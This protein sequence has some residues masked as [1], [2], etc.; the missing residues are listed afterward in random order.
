MRYIV[1]KLTLDEKKVLIEESFDYI[2]KMEIMSNISKLEDKIKKNVYKESF[3]V[4]YYLI[5]NG[6]N[7]LFHLLKQMS[8]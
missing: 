8:K 3:Y 5:K 1:P 7:D 6:M 2:S 4:H